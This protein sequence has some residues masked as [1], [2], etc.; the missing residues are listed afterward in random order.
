MLLLHPI[1]RLVCA[2]L[3]VAAIFAAKTLLA[4]S[5]VYLAVL[6]VVIAS[7]V[8]TN[9]LR[10]VAFVTLPL[11]LALVVVWGWVVDPLQIPASHQSGFTYALFTWLRIVACGGALQF[12][13]LP[14]IES[15]IQLKQFLERTGLSGSVG[16]LIVTSIVF[17]PEVRR[18]FLRIVD[19][20]KVQ[21]N[22]VSGLRGLRE[23]PTLLM[24][25]VSSLLES[26]TTRAELWSHRG[27]LDR[28]PQIA[29][30]TVPSSAQSAMAVALGFAAC[31]LAVFA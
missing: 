28:R 23:L 15:P 18:R 17:L 24:P 19:A 6:F 8:G 9:H 26:A 27:I 4:I 10:F 13:F 25:L 5:L 12:L 14:L 29:F 3:F 20:R 16:T 21:G 22:V 11:L 2:L 30:N 7:H 31:A 1:A